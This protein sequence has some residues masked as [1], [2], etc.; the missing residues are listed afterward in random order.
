MLQEYHTGHIRIVDLNLTDA[1]LAGRS[2]GTEAAQL[3]LNAP[4]SVD[5]AISDGD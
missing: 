1:A 5:F 4:G 2:D 3:K